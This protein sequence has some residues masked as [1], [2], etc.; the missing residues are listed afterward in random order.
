MLDISIKF[1]ETFVH[2]SGFYWMVQYLNSD[3]D[4]T[5]NIQFFTTQSRLKT[6]LSKKPFKNIE[7][8]GENASNQHFLLF[9]QCL[10]LY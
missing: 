6:T 1:T 2:E 4:K 9:P 3:L 10:Q 8:K 5:G 7:E